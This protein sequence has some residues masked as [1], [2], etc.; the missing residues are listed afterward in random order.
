[1]LD[2]ILEYYFSCVVQCRSDRSK[3]HKNIRAVL[4]FFNHSPYIFEMSRCS[5]KAVEDRSGMSM[6]V[7]VR[8]LI[9]T[10]S[11]V[12]GYM[13]MLFPSAFCLN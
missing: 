1:M 2:M 7:Y 11:I 13:H 5:R 6:V 12:A 3:L 4:S 10:M 8:M 9:R